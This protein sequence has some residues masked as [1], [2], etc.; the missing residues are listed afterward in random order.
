MSVTA[1]ADNYADRRVHARR[2]VHRTA[3]LLL[4]GRQDRVGCTIL[5]ESTGGLQLELLQALDLPEEALIKFSDTASQL[6]RRCWAKGN[7]AGYQFIEMVPAQRPW[8]GNAS[9][10]PAEARPAEARPA[11]ARLAGARLAEANFRAFNSF[12]HISSALLE[13]SSEPMDWLYP[14]EQVHELLL[15]ALKSRVSFERYEI[16]RN[17]PQLL[18]LSGTSW[19][20]PLEDQQ[21]SG[22][23]WTR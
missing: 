4:R 8:L 6:V 1:L 22:L 18:A 20:E 21:I 11:E 16:W 12:I 13:L 17:L 15:E 19:D 14:A 23:R 2:S 5:D 3:E 7:R 10:S 9:M